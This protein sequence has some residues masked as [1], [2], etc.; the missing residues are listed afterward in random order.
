MEDVWVRV[1]QLVDLAE[2]ATVTVTGLR[3]ANGQE[4]V[5]AFRFEQGEC[6][7]YVEGPAPQEEGDEG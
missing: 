2:R 7:R 1:R 3:D 6:V 5:L 4:V